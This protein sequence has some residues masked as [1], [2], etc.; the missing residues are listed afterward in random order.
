MDC[1][2]AVAQLNPRLGDLHANLALH[3]EAIA[4]AR[5][6]GA[7]LVAFSELSLTGYYLKDMVFELGLARDS[8]VLAR[9]AALSREISIAVG[10][11]ERTPEERFYNSLAFF[12]DGELLA[13]H[14][15]VHLVSYGMF[16]EAR[17]FAAGDEF[18]IIESKLGRFG[19][20]LCEDLWHVP[21]SY[22]H[23]LNDSDALLVASA[24]PTRGVEAPGPGPASQRTWETMLTACALFYRTWVVYAG[25]VGWEDGIG[26]GG[27]SAVV[28][29]FGEVRA[30]LDGLEPGLLDA[31]IEPGALRRARVET[32]LRRDEKPWILAAELARH[33]P[34]AGPLP[35]EDAAAGEEC[36]S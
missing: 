11:V 19:P 3:L 28:D 35:P 21:S 22:I 23:F 34:L 33:V 13:V 17:D 14:R 7:H 16:D 2:I 18:R 15:K 12:E 25:R 30:R 26:F 5:A 6:A 29:P 24:S 31:T 27:G 10:F 9:F 20:L 8:E 36:A 4:A 32:P 1:R